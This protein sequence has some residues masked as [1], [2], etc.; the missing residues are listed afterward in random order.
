MRSLEAR[1]TEGEAE[2]VH[3]KQEMR[4]LMSEVLAF[5]E[6]RTQSLAWKSGA[7][8]Y[9]RNEQESPQYLI[10]DSNSAIPVPTE[11]KDGTREDVH[12]EGVQKVAMKITAD[13]HPEQVH[14]EMKYASLF[15]M[16]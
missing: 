8:A 3:V 7:G 11:N 4:S 6:S 10:G 13:L 1:V 5:K 14:Y 12:E 9:Q 15:Y 16:S 2:L